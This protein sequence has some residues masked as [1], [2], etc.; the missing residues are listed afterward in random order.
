MTYRAAVLGLIPF[1]STL[2]GCRP[3]A[4]PASPA[5]VAVIDLGAG[6]TA[7]GP[8]AP[9]A[10]EK[11]D[12]EAGS[13]E[14]DTSDEPSAEAHGNRGLFQGAESP[15]GGTA[16]ILSADVA[17]DQGVMK[18]NAIGE[19]Y[20]VGGLG[21][22]GIGTGGGGTGETI[23]LG[24][25]GTF[26]SGAGTGAG[27]GSGA[28][29]LGGASSAL[30]KV[31]V[32]EPTVKGELPREVVQ[33]LIRHHVGRFRQCYLTGLRRNP[34][35]KGRM[36][37]T[38]VIG[39]EGSVT[40]VREGSSDMGNKDVS[41]CVIRAFQSMSFP[42]PKEGVVIVSSALQFE[43]APPPSADAAAAPPPAPSPAPS[44]ATSK[45]ATK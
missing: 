45:P 14:E 27:F 44:P 13:D 38:F 30:P 29:R 15:Y 25:I 42:M 18:G 16:S 20:G 8:A 31:S 36:N 32:T 28:G 34:A 21:L 1:V 10:P 4:P 5:E 11:P 24:T 26:R 17:M 41:A 12:Q 43:P 39:K 22:S 33:R 40:S 6:S 7:T 35:L 9:A 23:G 2:V 19:S 3:E 37:V